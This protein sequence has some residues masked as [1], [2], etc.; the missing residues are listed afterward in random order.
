MPR[1]KASSSSES[2]KVVDFE[3]SE[4]DPLI[5]KYCPTGIGGPGSPLLKRK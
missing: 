2:N 3:I 4:A 5:K 1:D